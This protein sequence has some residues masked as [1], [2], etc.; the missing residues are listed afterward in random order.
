MY[1]I[2]FKHFPEHVIRPTILA[3]SERFLI[4]IAETEEEIKIV[5][6]TV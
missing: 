5:E 4:K 2:D 1:Q 6:R 3:D